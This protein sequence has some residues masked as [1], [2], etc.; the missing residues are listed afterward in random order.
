MTSEWSKIALRKKDIRDGRC[1]TRGM[2][3]R[4]HVAHDS[5]TDPGSRRFL[6]NTTLRSLRNDSKPPV[7]A[8]CVSIT[9]SVTHIVHT[10]GTA[11]HTGHPDHTDE[12]H[13]TKPWTHHRDPHRD[14]HKTTPRPLCQPRG[15]LRR[16][17]PMR[18]RPCPLPLPVRS[19]SACPRACSIK[20]S[21]K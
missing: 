6:S 16:G 5:A 2:D 21:A 4:A 9:H 20:R 12:P 3:P 7:G 13:T 19:Q 17:R 8:V 14:T 11:G 18:T 15:Q 1:P 10:R